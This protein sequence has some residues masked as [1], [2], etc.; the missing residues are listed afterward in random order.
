M[1]V[2]TKPLAALALLSAMIS[3]TAW[4]DQPGADWI[5]M[6]RTQ[7]IL[8]GAGYVLVT[9]I[10]ADDGH[11]EGKGIKEDGMEYEFRMDPHSGKITQ[12]EKDD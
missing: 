11:W 5:S 8:K 2:L 4:A 6:Q 1:N 7:E 9:R 3:S 12:D 10:E